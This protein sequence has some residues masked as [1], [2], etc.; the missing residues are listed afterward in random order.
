MAL[1]DRCNHGKA[2][3]EPCPECDRIWREECVER[4]RQQAAK[5]G[6]KIV[7]AEQPGD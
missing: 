2:W 4:L 3:K 6:F 1:P 7:P 5:L